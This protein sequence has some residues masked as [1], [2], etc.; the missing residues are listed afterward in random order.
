MIH[1]NS[2]KACKV[3]VS[4]STNRRGTLHSR[5]LKFHFQKFREI[6][7]ISS[8]QKVYTPSLQG[9]PDSSIIQLCKSDRQKITEET[10]L[11]T[12]KH[13]SLPPPL[14]LPLS[15]LP[16]LVPRPLQRKQKIILQENRRC[17]P[18]RRHCSTEVEFAGTK[19][20]FRHLH[21]SL[22]SQFLSL[23]H[24]L[25]FEKLVEQLA[26]GVIAL[27]IIGPQMPGIVAIV[28][29]IPRMM[30]MNWGA[31]SHTFIK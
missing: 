28:L 11:V 1:I 9:S 19:E 2:N 18:N 16:S 24:K 29:E 27:T 26:C 14:F 20:N 10:V 6:Q 17:K 7:G 22:K 13:P 8:F 25:R 12:P 23:V 4:I 15:V 5:T 30:L 21:N 3:M 31:I